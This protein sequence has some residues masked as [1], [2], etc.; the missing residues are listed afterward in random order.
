ML[1]KNK[2]R[3]DWLAEGWTPNPKDLRFDRI[4]NLLLVIAFIV[5]TVLGSFFLWIVL[6]I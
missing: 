4:W 6:E 1:E 2:T 3:E 5:P